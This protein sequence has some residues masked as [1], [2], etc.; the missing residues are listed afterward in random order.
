MWGLV[1]MA[2]DPLIAPLLGV[3]LFQGLKPLQISEIARNAER[4]VFRAGDKITQAG[5][6]GDAAFLIVGGAAAWRGTL[7]AADASEPIEIGSLIGEM[8]MLIDHVYGATVVATAQVRCMKLNRSTMNQL[9]LDDASLAQHLTAKIAARLRRM[10]DALKAIDDDFG[11]E[12]SEL[13]VEEINAQ[14]SALLQ[15]H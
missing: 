7:S 13:P 10:A 14:V 8:A 3:E 11:L 9:M 4:I 6:N 2:M 5:A 12:A 1:F 15:L